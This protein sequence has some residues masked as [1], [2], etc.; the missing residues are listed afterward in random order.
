M[1][2]ITVAYLEPLQKQTNAKIRKEIRDE[3]PQYYFNSFRPY[4]SMA[5]R[6]C[7]MKSVT[8][9]KTCLLDLDEFRSLSP[10]HHN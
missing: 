5:E 7:A 8:E 9:R 3:L 4:R 1:E 10:L 6:V 2:R